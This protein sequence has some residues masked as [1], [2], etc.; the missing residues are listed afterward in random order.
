M[1]KMQ[2][3]L[4][5]DRVRD[6]L[7]YDHVTGQFVWKNTSHNSR[8]MAGENAGHTCPRH[9]YVFIGIDRVVYRAHR[10]A[11]A[12]FY[13]EWPANQIDH[14]N[15]D[16]QDNRIANLREAT[17]A[18]N[19]Q[20]MGIKK[21]N[22]SGVPGVSWHDRAGKWSAQI[23]IGGKKRHLGLFECRETAHEVYLTAKSK[24]HPFCNLDRAKGIY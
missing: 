11:W 13:G 20:N 3:Q 12:H 1:R 21:S 5:V 2:R 22:T 7:D 23:T 9:G 19:A 4:P 10:L 6:A 24:L 8:V 16:R 15:G 18:Q 14:I 17:N